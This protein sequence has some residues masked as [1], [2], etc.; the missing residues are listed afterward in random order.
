MKKLLTL[1]FLTIFA[2]QN[3]IHAQCTVNINAS[4]VAISNCIGPT[5]SVTT[6]TS[7]TSTYIWSV[8]GLGSLGSPSSATTTVSASGPGTVIVSVIFIDDSFCTATDSDTIEF[9]SPVDTFYRSMCPLPDTLCPLD[10][11]LMSLLSWNFVDST[12][13]LTGLTPTAS[14][15]VNVTQA[16]NYRMAGIY[17]TNCTVIH[18]YLVTDCATICDLDLG[19]DLL[20]ISNCTGPN[21]SANASGAGSFTYAWSGSANVTFFS[22]TSANP[23]VT[24]AG[25]GIETI[26]LSVTDSLGC[27]ASD[28]MNILFYSPVDTFY[29]YTCGFPDSLCI[30]NIDIPFGNP[31]WSFID[32]TGSSTSLGATDCIAATQNGTYQMFAIYETSCTVIHKYIVLD[33][34]FT[35]VYEHASMIEAG[36]YPNPASDQVTVLTDEP[37]TS[38]VILDATGRQVMSKINYHQVAKFTFSISGLLNGAYLMRIETEKGFVNKRLVKINR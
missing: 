5:I 35:S 25:P 2:F 29:S 26:T 1:L 21:L 8:T 11:P 34:C 14:N 4:P 37:L 23:T 19:P 16:G 3:S 38:L 17:E 18:D 28:T 31:S 6:S 36:L 9:V 30:L 32:S 24:A 15:C 27:I 12:G 10:C 7:F 33:T 13:G 22:S 20:A